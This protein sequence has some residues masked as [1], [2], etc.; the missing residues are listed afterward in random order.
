MGVPLAWNLS[1]VCPL[2]VIKYR[3]FPSQP[4]PRL[5]PSI[6]LRT[7][8]RRNLF[9]MILLGLGVYLFLPQFARIEHALRVVS[10]LSI[11]LVALAIGAQV[12]SYLGS[13]HPVKDRD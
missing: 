6:L 2:A 12:A 1:T 5:S 10:T 4:I 8:L 7:K 3:E 13:G 9:V 11:P